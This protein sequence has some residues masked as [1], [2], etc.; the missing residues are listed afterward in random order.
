MSLLNLPD[1][2]RKYGSLR[3]LWE[4]GGQGEQV[5]SIVK[6]TWG[7]YR[8]N[9]MVTML[10]RM[11]RQMAIKRIAMK[12]TTNQAMD[13]AAGVEQAYRN[14]EGEGN[15]DFSTFR[16]MAMMMEVLLRL[17]IKEHSPLTITVTIM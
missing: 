14:T 3:N 12:P 6:P 17:I 2:L 9:W 1:V 8:K 11:L 13:V 15:D 7:G 5:L 4:G 10:D 16:Q